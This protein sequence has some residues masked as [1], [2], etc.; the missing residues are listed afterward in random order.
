MYITTRQKK[1]IILNFVLLG[2]GIIFTVAAAL[3]ATNFFQ[4]AGGDSKPQNV[5]LSNLTASSITVTWI[6]D[7]KSSGIVEVYK[8][9]EKV[10]Q[11]VDSRGTD[12]WISHFVEVTDLSPATEYSF[13]II[14]NGDRYLNTNNSN[15]VFSTG[16]IISDIP[17]PNPV[18][19]NVKNGVASDTLVFFFPSSGDS[20]PLSTYTNASGSWVID[21]SSLRS[22][23]LKSYVNIEPKSDEEVVVLMNS[24][25]TNG[26]VAKGLRNALFDENGNASDPMV[27]D[28]TLG[29]LDIYSKI[30]ELSK[31]SVIIAETPTVEEQ[32]TQE[33]QPV[34][35]VPV[36]E[37]T[38]TVEEPVVEVPVEEETPSTTDDG[39]RTF[40]IVKDIDWEGIGGKSTVDYTSISS[41]EESVTIADLTDAGLTI[42]WLSTTKENGYVKYGESSS[43]LE[44]E[45]LDVRD[46]L[47][48]KG[49]FNS[50][51]IKL[52]R[53]KASTKYYYEVYSGT[54]VISSG[55]FTTLAT[56]SVPEFKSLNGEINKTFTGYSD[57]VIVAYLKTGTSLSQKISTISDANGKWVLSIGDVRNSDGTSF[58]TVDADTSIV[59]NTIALGKMAEFEGKISD[60]STNS[61]IL[62]ISDLPKSGTTKIT[63]LDN[64]GIR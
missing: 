34:V 57:S 39:V 27:K 17:T 36:E 18:S 54:Q 9:S 21:I 30:P 11:F 7:S 62:E 32:P 35:E 58:F 14:S 12:Q 45:A 63:L 15:F 52:S 51:N 37:E 2:V 42:S 4:N 44:L 31:L 23:D 55:D 24:G 53:L 6:T 47:T 61:I 60:Y 49:L 1:K 28:V 19:G 50:H 46:S 8:G 43:N 64:Y 38:P 10:G 40:R 26:A 41:G 56:L 48:S 59:I 5:V 29:S 33:E 3:I 25:G 16:P 13:K 20:Y 22:A